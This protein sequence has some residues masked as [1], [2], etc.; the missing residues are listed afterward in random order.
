MEIKEKFNEKL[1]EYPTSKMDIGSKNTVYERKS[2]QF[3]NKTLSIMRI[4]L[5][6]TE[7][8]INSENPK[9]I[10]TRSGRTVRRLRRSQYNQ[11]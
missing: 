9:V 6:L 8:R 11:A 10:T 5:V 7:Q 4:L 2:S 1:N 3:S